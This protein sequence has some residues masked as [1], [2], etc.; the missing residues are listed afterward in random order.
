MRAFGWLCLA[1]VGLTGCTRDDGLK[2]IFGDSIATTAGDFDDVGAPF[3]RMVVNHEEY[4]GLIS[5]ATWDPDYNPDNVA[6]KV[7]TLLGG[8]DLNEHRMVFVASGTRGLGKRQYN[9][10]DP[11]DQLVSDPAVAERLQAYVRNGGSVLVTDWAYDLVEAA[12]PDLIDFYGE[13]TEYDAAQVGMIGT[14]SADITDERLSDK[15]GMSVMAV[16]YDFSN[17]GVIESVDENDVTVWARGDISYRER[18]GEGE[19]NLTDVPLLV[20]AFPEGPGAGRV[21]VSTYHLDAQTPQVVDDMLR[22]VVDN[23]EEHADDPLE[24]IVE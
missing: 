9:G 8:A 10:L 20:S 21:V 13:D 17:W 4:E 24:P 23:F 3:D 15:L 14:V 22:V 11:D 5:V 16:D 7:E 6:L 19:R 2:S 1:A 18:D 12:W